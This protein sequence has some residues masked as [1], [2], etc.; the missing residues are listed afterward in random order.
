MLE[1]GAVVWCERDEFEVFYFFGVLVHQ[2]TLCKSVGM[3]V[4]S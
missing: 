4:K 3:Y 2:F 1:V